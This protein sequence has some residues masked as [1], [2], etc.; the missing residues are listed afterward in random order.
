MTSLL[1]FT[2]LA[3]LAIVLL[4]ESVFPLRKA[5]AAILTRWPGN[6]I[7]TVIEHGLG[8]VLLPALT[9]ALV[10]VHDWQATGLIAWFGLGPVAGFA[11]ILLALQ[12][13][14]YALHRA[15]HQIGWMWRIH[16]VHHSDTEVD[17]TTVHRHHPLEV[18]IG[19]LATLP[20]VFLLG[21]TPMQL[22]AYN[23]LHIAVATLSHGNLKLGARLDGWLRP[24]VVTPAYHRLHHAAERNYTDSN[25]ATLLPLFDH[26]FGTARRLPESRQATMTLGLEAF[27]SPREA[28]IA[29]LLQLPFT[30]H[31]AWQRPQP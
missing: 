26:L 9:L 30:R 2:V 4:A 24:F 7:L 23:V 11:V 3:S 13:V 21:P 28:G 18:I 25:Y 31:P 29:A 22:L 1:L 5:E 17:A 19:F 20:V 6:L 8:L 16:A 10:G 12:G 15:F 14:G 27:R